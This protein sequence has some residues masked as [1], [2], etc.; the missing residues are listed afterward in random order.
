MHATQSP[1]SGKRPS[2]F[3][4]GR[5]CAVETCDTILSIYNKYEQCWVHLPRKT[6]RVRGRE[7]NKS[8][9]EPRQE[10]VCIVCD[11][12]ESMDFVVYDGV[13]HRAGSKG[14]GTVCEVTT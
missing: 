2:T 12:S 4:E 7:L 8:E 3:E 9:P 6:P 10:V 11:Q 13:L 14:T 5:Y 1:L